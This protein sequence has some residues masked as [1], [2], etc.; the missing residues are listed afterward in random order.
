MTISAFRTDKALHLLDYSLIIA[1]IETKEGLEHAFASVE[2]LT[3]T[4]WFNTNPKCQSVLHLP[5]EVTE[6]SEWKH[7]EVNETPKRSKH[8]IHFERDKHL[9]HFERNK[10]LF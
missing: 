2:T 5:L 4:Q 3:I 6:K 9:I 7:S 8:L 10:H 1:R